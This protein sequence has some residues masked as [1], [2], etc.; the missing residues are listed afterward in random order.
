[1]SL[2]LERPARSI[3]DPTIRWADDVA[4]EM[5]TDSISS[6]EETGSEYDGEQRA[7]SKSVLEIWDDS[8][9]WERLQASRPSVGS[10]YRGVFP[11]AGRR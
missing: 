1:M 2:R 5:E 6:E 11:G 9:I 7:R 3:D 4:L 10:R 8:Y